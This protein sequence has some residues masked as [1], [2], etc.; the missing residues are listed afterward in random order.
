MNLLA[1]IN[2]TRSSI[3]ILIHH[4]GELLG[5]QKLE[6]LV[7]N[8][9]STP[10]KVQN[11]SP[12]KYLTNRFCV[13]RAKFNTYYM[14]LVCVITHCTMHSFKEQSCG[15]YLGMHEYEGQLGG[16]LSTERAEVQLDLDAV[17]NEDTERVAPLRV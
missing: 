11:L 15:R 6:F 7:D 9:K 8:I 17:G 14:T 3:D 12:L 1:V 2:S 5:P 16:E 13:N 10:N 4:Y